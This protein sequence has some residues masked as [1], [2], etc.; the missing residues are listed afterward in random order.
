MV[1]IKNKQPLSRKD[2]GQAIVF[3]RFYR[4]FKNSFQVI[5]RNFVRYPL[6]GTR[7]NG[8]VK[9]N[10]SYN[11]YEFSIRSTVDLKPDYF[12]NFANINIHHIQIDISKHVRGMK[13][14]SP[15]VLIKTGTIN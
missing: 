2:Y 13:K 12:G 10:P 14:L 7:R 3:G 11:P 9:M 5:H 1:R 4:D 8:T 6:F 15:F